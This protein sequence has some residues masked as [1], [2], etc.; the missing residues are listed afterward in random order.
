MYHWRVLFNST[1]AILPLLCLTLSVHICPQTAEAVEH[2]L[3]V[4][5]QSV[6]AEA[7]SYP[8]L[9]NR[10]SKQ[11]PSR[12]LIYQYDRLPLGDRCPFLMVH[13]LRGE[14]YRCFRWDKVARRLSSD[15]DFSRRFKIYMTRYD[16]IAELSENVPALRKAISALYQTAKQRPISILALS[17]G[18]NLAYESML[19]K[20]VDSKV[21]LLMT[22]A[23]PFRGSPL[24]SSD[25]LQYG[26]YKNLAMPWTRID[27]AVAYR[28]YFARNPNLLEDF[29]WDNNDNAIPNVGR[30]CSLIPFG[31]RGDLTVD[32]SANKRL[33]AVEQESIS[34]KVDHKKIIA[35][36]GYLLNP[37]L[38]P[39]AA[40]FIETTVM[41]PYTLLTVHVPAHLA[42]EHPV[43][44]MLNHTIATVVTSPEAS[45]R[46]KTPFVYGLNDGITPVSSAL[47][48]PSATCA[49]LPVS[50]ESD[51]SKLRNVVDVGT[52]RVFRNIDHLSFI[53]G[54]NPLV[55]VISLPLRDELNPQAGSRDIFSW[56]IN[57]INQSFEASNNSAKGSSPLTSSQ[58]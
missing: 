50:K 7:D 48:L 22:L 16:S 39:E 3:S 17:I 26:I 40:R 36:S 51:L 52:A 42:R 14:Y 56:I 43:L 33:V 19:D 57:D 13:G 20:A 55:K 24:F 44:K 47:F 54:Y 10:R 8:L 9:P 18:G 58:N 34:H 29:R 11:R 35:Y 4:V 23:T 49:T 45:N 28:L 6:V 15:R 53:D 21:S 38:K 41:S 32:S 46:A 25:W 12:L 27:H 5:E 37:Y 31:P 2:Q 1:I 30:F